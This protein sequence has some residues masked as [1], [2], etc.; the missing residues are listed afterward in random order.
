MIH[1]ANL[2]PEA[3]FASGPRLVRYDCG[4]PSWHQSRAGHHSAAEATIRHT[5]AQHAAYMATA[6]LDYP[7]SAQLVNDHPSPQS[8]PT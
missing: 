2:L 6:R 1:P 7:I 3:E 5:Y 4:R 8:G